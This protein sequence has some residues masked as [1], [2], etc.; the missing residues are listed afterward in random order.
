MDRLDE[1][2]LEWEERRDRGEP[3]TPEVLCPNDAALAA[4]LA[5]RIRLIAAFD[6][7]TREAEP[8]VW[9]LSERQLLNRIWP[10][11]SSSDRP[12]RIGKYEVR[13]ILGVGRSDDEPGGQIRH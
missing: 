7:L 4:Q 8:P 3:V 5:E 6:D 10:P 9:T 13:A 2:M 1:L 11:G 12:E